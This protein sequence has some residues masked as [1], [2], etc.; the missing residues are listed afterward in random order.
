[1]GLDFEPVSD[2]G[3]V[4]F[5]MAGP[6]QKGYSVPEEV[7]LTATAPPVPTASTKQEHNQYDNQNRF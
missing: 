7:W 5:C 1:M 4:A 6:R 2:N 3:G